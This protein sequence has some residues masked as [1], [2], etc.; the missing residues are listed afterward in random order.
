MN[1]PDEYAYDALYQLTQ[2]T[3]GGAV[4]ESYQYDPVGNRLNLLGV[5][6]YSHDVSNHLTSTSSLGFTYDA[7]GNTLVKS[8]TSQQPAS[9]TGYTWDAENRLASVVLPGSGGTV[10]FKYDPFGR[11]IQKSGPS[12]VTIYA[13]DGANIV[14]EYGASG[15]LAAKYAQGSG[16][17]EP[18]A[19]CRTLPL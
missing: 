4:A 18:L 14:A 11:R 9:A 13:Y 5:S 15:A 3:R 7:N 2:V 19:G 8:D 10:T 12:G 6:S 17:D 16:I 1:D